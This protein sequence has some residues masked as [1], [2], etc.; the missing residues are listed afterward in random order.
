MAPKVS[1]L[2]QVGFLFILCLWTAMAEP[3]SEHTKYKDPK[4]PLNI[5]IRDLMNRMTLAE[6]IGQM[7]QIEKANATHEKLRDYAFGSILSTGGSVPRNE[8]SARGLGQHG[9]SVSARFALKPP[10]NSHDLC[11]RCSARTQQCL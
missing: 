1:I 4:Q 9:E 11:N 7:I 10:W 5:R 3:K 2:P 8:A 6:K